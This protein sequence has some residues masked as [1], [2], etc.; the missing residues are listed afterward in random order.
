MQRKVRPGQ[1]V[2]DWMALLT[3]VQLAV[4]KR[5]REVIREA[6][7]GIEEEVKWGQPCFSKGGKV[8][9]VMTSKSHFTLGFFRGAELADPDGLLAGSGKVMRS[10]KL[11]RA[12][13]V[14]AATIRAWIRQAV[15]LNAGA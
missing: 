5:L 15:A 2:E 10:L 11:T 9:Y 1:T 3:P 6:S 12:E 4:M 14:P 13:D 8:A 7:P